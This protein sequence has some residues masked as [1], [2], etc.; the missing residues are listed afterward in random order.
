MVFVVSVETEPGQPQVQSKLSLTRTDQGS[1][2][3]TFCLETFGSFKLPDLF[4]NGADLLER[5][6]T[7][8]VC[9]IEIFN[10]AFNRVAC[11]C[12]LDHLI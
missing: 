1:P 5:R 12:Y 9:V 6:S 7:I 3:L 10:S 11:G 8:Y 2:G 4:C